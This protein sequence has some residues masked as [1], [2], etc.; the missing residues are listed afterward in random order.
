MNGA[1]RGVGAGDR[2]IEKDHHAV[3]CEALKGPLIL[4][5]NFPHRDMELMQHPHHFFWLGGLREGRK[6]AQIAEDDR[7]LAA[8][9]LERLLVLIRGDQLRQLPGRGNGA[10]E[11]SRSSSST[12]RDT[13]SSR[14]LFHSASCDAWDWMVS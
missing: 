11:A 3:P 4:V 9:A 7:D 14:V 2:I 6:S 13:R 1:F 5:N 10:A 12:C 8:V